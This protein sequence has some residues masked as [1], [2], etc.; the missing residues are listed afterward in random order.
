MATSP[1]LRRSPIPTSQRSH[2]VGCSGIRW[3]VAEKLLA[4]RRKGR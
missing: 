2:G 3:P 1:S 4:S